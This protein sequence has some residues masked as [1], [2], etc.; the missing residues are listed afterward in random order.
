MFITGDAHNGRADL[1]L[2]NSDSKIAHGA[3]KGE[4]YGLPDHRPEEAIHL[5]LKLIFLQPWQGN[6]QRFSPTAPI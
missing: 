1:L 3:V 5:G 4:T 6:L 2:T